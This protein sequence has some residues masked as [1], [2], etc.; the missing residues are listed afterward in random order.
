MPSTTV[1]LIPRPT[2]L[3][4]KPGAFPLGPGTRV[5]VDSEA[6]LDSG[7]LLAS[8]LFPVTGGIPV[9]RE[10]K[11][12][13]DGA[14]LLTLQGAN[15][16][17]GE[18]GY[19]LFIS[20][21]SSL[22]TART[23][24]GIFRGM[25][26]VRQL[27]LQSGKSGSLACLQIWDR[28]RYAWRGMHLDCCRHFMSVEFVKRYIDLLALHKMNVFHW[29][30]TEDQ[31]WRLEIKKYP[32]LTQVSAWREA[33]WPADYEPKKSV[34]RRRY[35]GYYTQAQAREIVAYAAERHVTVVPEIE[36]PGH[37]VAVLAAYPELSCT[38]AAFKVQTAWGV[39]KD[40]FCAGNDQTFKFLEGVLSEVAEIFP[41]PFIHLGADEC[42]KDRWKECPKCQARMKS[43]GLKNERKLQTYFIHR[44]VEFLRKKGKRAI[45]WDEIL[46][47][48]I[49]KGVVLQAWRGR[50]FGAQAARQ[51]AEAVVSPYSHVYF[52]H[53]VKSTNLEKTYSF[54]P[55]PPGLTKAQKK[56]ILGSE[57]CMW[58]EGTPQDFID[59]QVFPRM[60]ALSEVLWSQRR[61]SFS[62]FK[63]RLKD[64][65]KGLES[66]GVKFGPAE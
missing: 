18:E 42:P 51:G 62:G 59:L 22:L 6:L 30:L 27:I 57:G 32:K 25:Q 53:G 1:S 21:T 10:G 17:L 38:G 14:I 13:P 52:D 2:R 15:A 65:Q 41:G 64:H 11:S 24:Q 49:P 66:M 16:Q 63:R 43:L 23:V 33:E 4:P 45:C 46:E 44:M 36:M 60:V 5:V 55:T 7:R 31:G 9:V 26:T 34:P 12:V 19:E 35:G 58:T 47:G 8:Y 20:R 37:T 56:K 29:H 40:V 3:T 61:D 50:K 28:P 54:Q 39:H 48:G